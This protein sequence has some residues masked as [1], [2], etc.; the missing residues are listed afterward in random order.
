M[1]AREGMRVGKNTSCSR[2]H[3]APSQIGP[4]LSATVRGGRTYHPLLGGWSRAAGRVPPRPSAAAASP[5]LFAVRVIEPEGT[6]PRARPY[7]A[8][9]PVQRL[10]GQRL[11]LHRDVVPD[12][13][14]REVHAP[15]PTL[16][17]SP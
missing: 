4:S 14:L 2:G 11:G 6:L 5:A 9:V 15:V 12:A 16:N 1:A 13:Y 10:A 3:E 17:C 7:P 8:L